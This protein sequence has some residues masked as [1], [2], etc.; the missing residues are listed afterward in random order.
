M[1]SAICVP[2]RVNTQNSS[3]INKQTKYTY[4]IFSRGLHQNKLKQTDR[5]RETV[6]DVL[7]QKNN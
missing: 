7:T 5:E 3:Y 2:P 1:A 4:L 6:R